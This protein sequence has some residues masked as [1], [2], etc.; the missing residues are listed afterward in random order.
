M[1]QKTEKTVTWFTCFD[2]WA[3]DAFLRG[4][5]K[6]QSNSIFTSL[7]SHIGMVILAFVS[8]TRC[9]LG[10]L[11][12][13]FHFWYRNHLTRL[14]IKEHTIDKEK[15]Q[16]GNTTNDRRPPCSPYVWKVCDHTVLA[17]SFTVILSLI[18]CRAWKY[19]RLHSHKSWYE[20][21]LTNPKCHWMLFRDFNFIDVYGN[22][23]YFMTPFIVNY[24]APHHVQSMKLSNRATHQKQK[25]LLWQKYD[26]AKKNEAAISQVTWGSHD[27][28]LA[29]TSETTLPIYMI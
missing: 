9:L 12:G 27:L 20:H 3:T 18:N 26:V 15:A 29:I 4:R 2:L 7:A 1:G 11:K 10:H 17:S 25:V 6:H 24:C 14:R 8:S 19:G 28:M 13:L 23:W 5:L 22:M 16:S 21:R